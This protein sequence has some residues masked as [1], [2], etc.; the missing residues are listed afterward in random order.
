MEHSSDQQRDD[1]PRGRD[2]NEGDRQERRVSWQR[3]QDVR[4]SVNA[5]VQDSD[6]ADD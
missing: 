5:A 1:E 2:R 3:D 4:R 6:F